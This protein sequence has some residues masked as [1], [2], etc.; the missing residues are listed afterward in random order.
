MPG[1]ALGFIFVISLNPPPPWENHHPHFSDEN[2]E[3][4]REARIGS[5][6][7]GGNSHR[8]FVLLCTQCQPL[9]DPHWPPEGRWVHVCQ[10][11]PPL[12]F[13]ATAQPLLPVAAGQ[14]LTSP[15]AN[16]WDVWPWQAGEGEVPQRDIGRSRG[17]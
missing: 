1:S 9:Q 11:R 6:L 14:S 3:A 2:T 17:P 15:G 10:P 13:H 5:R 8:C 4:Q 12:S 16:S 7:L